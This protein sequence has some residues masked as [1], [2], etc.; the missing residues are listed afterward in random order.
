MIRAV[1]RNL[2]KTYFKLRDDQTT[3]PTALRIFVMQHPNKKAF[4]LIELLVVISIIALLIGILLPALASARAAA[5]RIACLSNVRQIVTAQSAYA[6]D[7]RNS[8]IAQQVNKVSSFLGNGEF[9]VSNYT[10]PNASSE[11]GQLI[12]GA[13]PLN[14]QPG[15]HPAGLGVLADQNYFSGIEALWCTEPPENEFS[16]ESI[17][18]ENTQFGIDNWNNDS[19]LTRVGYATYH[20]RSVY[21][22]DSIQAADADDK[23]Y[24]TFPKFDLLG[25]DRHMV[26]CPRYVDGSVIGPDSAASHADLGINTGYADGSGTFLSFDGTDYRSVLATDVNPVANTSTFYSWLDSRGDDLDLYRFNGAEQ[27]RP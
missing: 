3:N 20:S 18:Q 15:P 24:L 16:G 17:G 21:I 6:V 7:Y 27:E 2:L 9:T 26:N 8:V 22:Q 13:G 14:G 11:S 12:R 25:S 1:V 23:F 19:G 5:R 10:T 4:T